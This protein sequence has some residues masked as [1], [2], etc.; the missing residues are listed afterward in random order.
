MNWI[1]IALGIGALLAYAA[2]TL[3]PPRFLSLTAALF[4]DTMMRLT[5]KWAAPVSGPVPT[6]YRVRWSTSKNTP[7]FPVTRDIPGFQDY[8]DVPGP[9]ANQTN[10]VTVDVWAIVNGK[11]TP[12]AGGSI[13]LAGSTQQASPGSID[14]EPAPVVPPPPPPTP[15]PPSPTLGAWFTAFVNGLTVTLDGRSSTGPVVGWDWLLDKFPDGTASGPVIDTTYPHSGSRNVTLTVRDAVGNLAS[16]TLTVVIPEPVPVPVPGPVPV[17]PPPPPSPTPPPSPGNWSSPGSPSTTYPYVPEPA[18]YTLPQQEIDTRADPS[19]YIGGGRTV[20]YVQNAAE[21]TT[22]LATV[23]RGEVVVLKDNAL[24]VGNFQL[25][26]GRPG[27]DPIY[28]LGESLY[29]GRLAVPEGTRATPASSA[30]PVVEGPDYAPPVFTGYDPV[31]P[32]TDVRLAG[33]QVRIGTT[34]RRSDGVIF[35]GDGGNREVTVAQL[36]K[37]I[38]LDRMVLRGHE[39]GNPNIRRGALMNG[40]ATAL[41]DSWVDRIHE[42]GADT[43]ACLVSNS[44]GPIKIVG[45]YLE[46]SGENIMGGGAEPDIPGLV[47]ADI[48]VRRNHFF[49]P[50]AWKGIYSVKNLYEWKSAKRVLYEGNVLENNWPSGQDGTSILFQRVTGS[51]AASTIQDIT[52]RYN[53]VIRAA[54]VAS[55]LAS[56]YEAAAYPTNRVQF[57]HMLWTDIADAIL[58]NPPTGAPEGKGFTLSLGNANYYDDVAIEHCTL[59]Y[60]P[61]TMSKSWSVNLDAGTLGRYRRLVLMNN[62]FPSFAPDPGG[63]ALTASDQITRYFHERAVAVMGDGS[64][65]LGYNAYTARNPFDYPSVGSR[66]PADDAAIDYD[67]NSRPGPY[68]GLRGAASDGLDIGCDI[69]TLL[70]ATAG[71]KA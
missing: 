27:M 20:H 33:F 26:T 51:G 8:A 36:P 25:P 70:I 52:N 45:N 6:M 35:I 49:K 43:Q 1:V 44:P 5:A 21:L 23:Q 9:L 67:A 63:Y 2:V 11:L 54:S 66:F 34:A 69:A 15:P 7:G 58:N 56:G 18:R 50:L 37:R 17:P 28:V 12:S 57:I 24:F 41:V 46:A 65:Q 40:V 29:A 10:R 13:V 3:A 60:G 62:I 14:L 22:A 55:V 16:V 47:C 42:L 64:Q 39:N 31:N 30:W 53:H 19:F 71:V 61:A 32:C 48:T 59:R 4:G 38:T 68:S